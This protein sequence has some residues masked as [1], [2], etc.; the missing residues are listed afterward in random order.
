MRRLLLMTSLLLLSAATADAKYFNPFGPFPYRN[1]NP[2]Y[3]Q[4]GALRPTVATALP[5]GFWRFDITTAYA[6]VYNVAS[7]NGI[8]ENMDMEVMRTALNVDVGLPQGIEAGFEIPFL[9]ADGGF[10]DDAVQKFHNLF[11]FPNA[12]RELRP[13]NQFHSQITQNGSTIYSYNPIGFALS[14]VSFRLK[15]QAL[16]EGLKA[17]ALA[18][19]GTLKLPTGS[20]SKG[21]GNGNVDVGLGL[22]TQKSFGR[23][24]LF[25]NAQWFHTGGQPN[26]NNLMYHDYMN[27][28]AGLEISLGH[29]TSLMLQMNGVTPIFKNM[30]SSVWD[31]PTAELLV[32]VQ[33]RYP[34]LIAGQE[35]HW[36]LGFVEDAYT[37]SPAVDF[38]AFLN[39]G[40]T[41]DMFARN[42]YRGD[43][44]AKR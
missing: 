22:A 23:W 32:G 8:S 36:Q 9:R 24:H 38:T 13:N 30:G 39:V 34:K 21:T 33:G 6:S 18:V 41:F 40:I 4:M 31:G 10:L 26:L 44:W 3:L 25:V 15:W 43:M 5:T 14:D 1:M 17:P 16:E 7:G 37:N 20:P 12:G 28:M 11:G 35:F 19:L 27:W 2:L 29:V 42:R